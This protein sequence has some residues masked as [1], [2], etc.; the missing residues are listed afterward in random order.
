MGNQELKLL[1]TVLANLAHA[2]D[3]ADALPGRNAHGSAVG[4]L[5]KISVLA[6]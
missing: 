3:S 2:A 4:E 1:G 6:Y 5:G